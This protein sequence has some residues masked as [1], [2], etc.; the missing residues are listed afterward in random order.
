[1]IPLPTLAEV[2]RAALE[3]VAALTVL[4]VVYWAGAASEARFQIHALQNLHDC[5][6]ALDSRL[7]PAANRAMAVV[8]GTDTILM[9]RLSPIE[10]GS[11][12]EVQ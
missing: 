8:V 7:F 10:V 4:A 3:S 6:I 5:T 9:R 11:F 12:A 1:M 2:A